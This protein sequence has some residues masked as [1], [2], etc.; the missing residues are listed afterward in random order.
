[1]PP[2]TV[3]GQFPVSP[4]SPRETHG[5]MLR[6]VTDFT[7]P[8]GVGLGLDV[9]GPGQR[10]VCGSK[11]EGSGLLLSP[12]T[13]TRPAQHSGPLASKRIHPLLEPSAEG[14]AVVRRKGEREAK[15]G[16]A[17]SGGKPNRGEL[18]GGGGTFS[19]LTLFGTATHQQP[20][21][22]H[23]SGAVARF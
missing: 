12:R 20:L 22:C 14:D 18:G 3:D 5:K 8:M 21:G 4:P 13:R 15:W 19:R 10:Q 7:Q 2:R 6:R 9:R 16:G 17:L 11:S 1:M 23:H